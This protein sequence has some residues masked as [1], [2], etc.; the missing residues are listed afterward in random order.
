MNSTDVSADL[1]RKPGLP[2]KQPFFVEK[3]TLL[4]ISALVSMLLGGCLHTPPVVIPGDVDVFGIAICSVTDYREIRG[5]AGSDELCLKG[6]ERSFD[7]L[8]LV[9]GYDRKG[10]VR[11]IMTQNP[12]NSIF[13]IRAGD[14]L[15]QALKKARSAGFRDTATPN[16]FVREGLLLVF[17]VNSDNRVF[18]VSLESNPDC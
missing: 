17:L 16:R 9:I 2:N 3:G 11:K 15:E 18:G 1:V 10:A 14:S 5:V 12:R 13:G 7:P 6:Y 8:D 4:L